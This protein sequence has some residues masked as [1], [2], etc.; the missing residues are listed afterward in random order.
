MQN[1]PLDL[2]CTHSGHACLTQRAHRCLPH[3]RTTSL[4][5][6]TTFPG[7]RKGGSSFSANR[8]F[9]FSPA[10]ASPL[11]F[12]V[13]ED[14]TPSYPP[15]IASIMG[16]RTRTASSLRGTLST[17][18][19]GP[20]RIRSVPPSMPGPGWLTRRTPLTSVR[21]SWFGEVG[22]GHRQTD[23]PP[24]ARAGAGGPLLR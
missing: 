2:I 10:P 3:R 9:C 15:L 24:R 21:L 19:Q 4:L 14:R 23:R 18:R 17:R 5:E 7:S 13:L 6:H 22:V 1:V 8:P 16:A 11:D 12:E 20:Q